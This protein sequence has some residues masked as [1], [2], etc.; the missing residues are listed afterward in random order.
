LRPFHGWHATEIAL[1]QLVRRERKTCKQ[2]RL[3]NLKT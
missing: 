2:R 3:K 1:G